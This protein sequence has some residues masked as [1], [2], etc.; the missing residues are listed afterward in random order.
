MNNVKREEGKKYQQVTQN[1]EGQVENEDEG[2]GL[3]T[4]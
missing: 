4:A 2:G 1:A 3:S